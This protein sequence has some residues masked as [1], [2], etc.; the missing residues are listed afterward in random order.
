M[1]PSSSTPSNLRK[2]LP[3]PLSYLPPSTLSLLPPLLSALSFPLTTILSQLLQRSPLLGSLTTA[4]TFPPLLP[5]RGGLP[6]LPAAA[7]N[8]ATVAIAGCVGWSIHS[9]ATNYL[10]PSTF[11]SSSS[12]TSTSTLSHH[13]RISLLTILTFSL[14]S[15]SLLSLSP[16]S[17][18]A[19]GAFARLSLPATMDYATPA[20]RSK[21]DGIYRSFGC[22]TCG[23]K[24]TAAARNFGSTL[25]MFNADHI[26]PIS[27]VNYYNNRWYNR[28]VGRKI[29]Q[30]FYP[31]CKACSGVQGASLAG[32][33]LKAFKN[34][35][36]FKVGA[37]GV[38]GKL[39][40]ARLRP[41]H[42]TNG[43]V[44]VLAGRADD[45][46]WDCFGNAVVGYGWFRDKE[47]WVERG[48]V[49]AWEWAKK[50]FP[51]SS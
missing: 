27:L 43:L 16:S 23:V 47:V 10:Y 32:N 44:A 28:L 42:L 30:V 51:K 1:L 46:G 33:S 21:L 11:P 37:Q 39:H 3:P 41:H 14:L 5:R 24:P 8:L 18:F 50:R 17:Y 34:G 35:A 36:S 7:V 49:D 38:K 20:A 6:R 31:Q 19:P 9:K 13:F 15:P 26:P 22:H 4:D 40:L 45:R 25:S 48:L 2:S 12:S 29:A